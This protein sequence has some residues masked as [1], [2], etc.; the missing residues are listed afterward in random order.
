MNTRNSI[1]LPAIGTRLVRTFRQT[2]LATHE[3]VFPLLCP[4]REREWLPDWDARMIHS[5]SGLAEPG[6][7]FSTRHG[8]AETV[9]V[10][11]EHR[12]SYRVRFTRWHPGEMVVDCEL[13]LS[14]PQANTTWLDIRYTYTATAPA[15]RAR[16]EGMTQQQ[17]L[18]Q[19]KHWESH[20]N[21]FLAARR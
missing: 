9:W 12:P 18:E 20:L 19:M 4:V 3:D 13:D 21:A 11:V 10:I 15:G 5:T 6:A 7:V 17:W 2:L 14:S 16:I 8:D 1:P